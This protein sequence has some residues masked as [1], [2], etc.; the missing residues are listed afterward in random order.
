MA[1]VLGLLR[2]YKLGAWSLWYDEALALSDA[3]GDEGTLNPLGYLTYRL[4]FSGLAVRPSE[5]LLRL[6]AALFGFVGVPLTFL[7]FRRLVP[8]RQAAAAALFVAVSQWHVYWS[9]NARF[10]TLELDLAL[11]GAALT[12]SGLLRGR[13]LR[14]GVGLVALAFAALAHPSAAFL[15][16]GVLLGPWIARGFG[17]LGTG[18]APGPWRVLLA[19]GVGLVLFGAPW[20]FE[21]WGTWVEKKAAS[22]VHFVMTTGFYVS[23]T[24]GAGALVGS[25]LALRRRAPLEALVVASLGAGLAAATVASIF[26]RMSAQYVFWA[27]PWLALLAAVPLGAEARRGFLSLSRALGSAY[28]L[29]ILLPALA[30]LALYFSVG[31]GDRPRWREAYAYVLAESEPGDLILGMDAPVGEYYLDP[32][33]ARVDLR[34]WHEVA[35]LDRF[36]ANLATQWSRFPRRTWVIMNREQLDDW[37]AAE[38]AGFLATLRQEFRWQETFGVEASA[39]DL[40]VLVYL[41]E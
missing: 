6:P 30:S 37:S 34:R 27:L 24:L 26:A 41:R 14:V 17:L 23:P 18:L 12:F 9:Q 40:D 33:P 16:G 32:D 15:L 21:V 8:A 3:M 28:G 7:A 25:W 4:A 39:R 1:L 22:P 36:R 35:Y 10:Y 19:A 29:L 2:F 5:F 11:A 20:A 31:H 38:R 13:M